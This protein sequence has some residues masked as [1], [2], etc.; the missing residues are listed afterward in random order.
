MFTTPIGCSFPSSERSLVQLN[1]HESSLSRR[2]TRNLC[3]WSPQIYL[4]S[5]LFNQNSLESDSPVKADPVVG[6]Q[7]KI[8][9]VGRRRRTIGEMARHAASP[10]LALGGTI[11]IRL[12]MDGR[13]PTRVVG[14]SSPCLAR[15]FRLDY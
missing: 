10:H 3:L 11:R 12:G 13:V 15:R 5:C 9:S 1:T 14:G 7:R 8:Y 2:A 4:S 6:V